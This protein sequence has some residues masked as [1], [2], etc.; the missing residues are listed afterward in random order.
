MRWKL[1][2]RRLSVSAPRMIVRSHLP[3]PLRWAAAAVVLGFCGA[4]ALWA[5]EFGKG[6]A[7]LDRDAEAE[8]VSLRAEVARLRVDNERAVAVA[9]TVE[10]LLRAERA[11]QE[12]LAQ[13]VR[14]LEDRKRTLESDLGFYERL[15]PAGGPGV[16]VRGL[17]AEARGPGKIRVRML[18]TQGGAAART[19]FV[20]RYEV[21]LS[22]FHAGRSWIRTQAGD[23]REL[24]L[25]QVLRVEAMLDHPADAMVK[26]VLVKV[27]DEEGAVKAS[28]SVA[29]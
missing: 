18:L 27:L 20:G 22:G 11:T 25:R 29:L 7:G 1:L 3:W 8:L 26:A 17:Q 23:P 5:F 15:L 21:T 14:E 6:I 16:S 4:I 19:E 10:S 24:R 2:R 28:Q 9:N 12:R 13:N